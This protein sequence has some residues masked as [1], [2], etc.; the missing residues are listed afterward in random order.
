MKI[1]VLLLSFLFLT[2]NGWAQTAIPDSIAKKQQYRERIKTGW[3]N[4]EGRMNIISQSPE[5]VKY[6][7]RLPE[8]SDVIIT[9][10]RDSTFEKIVG[11]PYFGLWYSAG[12]FEIRGDSIYL[13][14]DP[15]M[16]WDMFHRSKKP[17]DYS[18]C[19]S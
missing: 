16:Y 9:L 19:H 10:W 18:E 8:S 1:Y 2:S 15:N 5:K 12:N 13:Y 14:P 7:F 6:Q 11:S 3:E 4:P 17:W